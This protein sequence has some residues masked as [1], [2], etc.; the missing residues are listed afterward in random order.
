MMGVI[1]GTHDLSLFTISST[2]YLTRH[3]GWTLFSSTLFV[4]YREDRTEP[5]KKIGCLKG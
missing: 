3:S 4:S 1:K 2:P 5:G